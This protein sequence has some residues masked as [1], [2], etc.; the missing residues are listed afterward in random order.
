MFAKVLLKSAEGIEVR[1]VHARGW[2][3]VRK[4]K[5]NRGAK[6]NK[7]LVFQASLGR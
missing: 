2:G 5:H 3:L 1:F 6:K 4:E 7:N